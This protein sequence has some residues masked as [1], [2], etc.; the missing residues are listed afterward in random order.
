MN[1]PPQPLIWVSRLTRLP[2][3]AVDDE[4][5]GRCTDVV[6]SAAIEGAPRVTGF[7]AEV[8]RRP[9][10]VNGGRV[11][12]ID[13][14]GITLRTG[15]L[16]LRHFAQRPYELLVVGDL[17]DRKHG[18]EYINDIALRP[19]WGKAWGWEVA[20]VSLRPG[21]ALRRRSRS[22]T[23]DWDD[24]AEL[25]DLGEMSREVA[26]LAEL[27][28]ADV[29]AAL[30]RMPHERRRRLAEAMDDERL[31]DLLEE[32]PED[33]QLR[34]VEGLDMERVAD[35][36][37]E[38]EPDDAADLLAEMPAQMRMRLLE[39][40]EPDD[41]ESMR[42]LLLYPDQTAGALMTPEPIVLPPNATVATALARLRDPDTTSTLAAQ[43]FVARPPITTP[44]GS[45]IGVIGFQRLLRE[46]PG[47]T[48][49]R[50]V[51]PSVEPVRPDLAESR[52]A[53]LF[54][55]YDLLAIPVCDETGRL[56]GAVTVDD[57][58]DA[59]LPEGWRRTRTAPTRSAAP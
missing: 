33:E 47:V 14:S 3:R 17:L 13:A 36:V 31:A 42:R 23:V 7:I 12:A 57:V 32:L 44:T 30:R 2:L 22:R 59:V 25:F 54:A 21:G 15:T 9:I 55:A 28:P 35:I 43:V 10:F 39:E 1:Q 19:A 40:M 58:L 37:E 4:V 11:G 48:L 26:S 6:V 24:A 27:H 8:Q 34:L 5:I 18:R 51:D 50:C 56:L 20:K 16:D 41:A 49:D 52:L 38:M 45:Y 53:E 46:Q 29:A